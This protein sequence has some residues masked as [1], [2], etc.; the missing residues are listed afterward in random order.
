MALGL[1]C[2]CLRSNQTRI[3]SVGTEITAMHRNIDA[4]M[5]AIHI[6]VGKVEYSDA[7]IRRCKTLSSS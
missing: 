1:W 7:S 2:S 4:E 5:T 3:E 6:H